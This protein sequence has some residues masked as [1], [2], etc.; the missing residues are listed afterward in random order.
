MDKSNVSSEPSMSPIWI[1]FTVIVIVAGVCLLG[2]IEDKDMKEIN[3][4][5]Y[6]MNM[7]C[8]LDVMEYFNLLSTKPA[9][10]VALMCATLLAV[11]MSIIYAY[12][13][14]IP[15]IIYFLIV[16]AMS[17]IVMSA[18]LSYYTFHVLVPNGGQD[19]WNKFANP[20]RPIKSKFS[21]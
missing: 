12:I 2:Y 17:W 8:P 20:D 19:N 5:F 1:V 21:G 6:D 15:I 7:L 3:Q 9:W 10:R 16:L 13:G 18:Y 4:A 11:V 14:Q